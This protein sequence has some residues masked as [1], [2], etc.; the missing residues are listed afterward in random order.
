VAA[1][2]AARWRAVSRHELIRAAGCLVWR[3]TDDPAVPVEIAVV[4][5]PRR[6][7]W[8]L[9]KG[10]L[11]PAEPWTVAARREVLEETGLEV[12]LG[13][14]LP[15][16]RYL[17]EGEPK[18]VR[19]WAAH[20]RSAEFV[21]NVEVDELVWLSPGAA[22]QR[23][24][25][26]H[27]SEVLDGFLSMHHRA[28]GVEPDVL[29]VLRHTRAVKRT[30]WGGTDSDRPLEPRGADDAEALVPVLLSYGITDVHASDTTR[31]LDSVAPY[32]AATG[33][34]AILEPDVSEE[35]YHRKPV[36]A[37]KRTHALLDA[38]GRTVLCSH[39]PV[40]PAI[41]TAALG[42][43]QAKRLIG[44]GMPPGSMVVIHHVRGQVL[45]SERHDI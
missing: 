34:A 37:A 33:R 13:P 21:A 2:V 40:L 14:P 11:G 42:H 39:R 45:A 8:S 12:V 35:T 41:L 1:L 19:Y 16:Q 44:A 26:P 30:D 22:R 17:V 3:R 10:K 15:T 9:P 43:K 31:T 28:N 18:V 36:L 7:D 27:D 6:D 24:S 20:A 5:R 32:V 4:H 29:V 23:L 38:G 25:Y